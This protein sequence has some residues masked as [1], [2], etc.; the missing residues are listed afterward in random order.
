[1]YLKHGFSKEALADQ[2]KLMKLISPCLSGGVFDSPYKFLKKYD[3]MTN[4]LTKLFFCN[5][6]E[7]EMDCD[8]KTGNP[9]L[10]Q[11]CGHPFQKSKASYSVFLPLQPQIA[12]FIENHLN[13]SSKPIDDD[14]IGDVPTGRVY[15]SYKKKGKLKENSLTLQWNMDGAR[16][17]ELSEYGFM[18]GMGILNE[19]KHKVRRTNIILF[20][21]WYGNKKPQ[22]KQF[23]DRLIEMLNQLSDVGVVVNGVKWTVH[24][25]IVSVDTIER[26][27]LRGTTQF[28]GAFGC[29]FCLIEGT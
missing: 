13:D 3:A 11:A 29:D 8:P 6:S 22:S 28:N 24:L 20:G 21:I 5:V 17:F 2:L 16:C 23:L 26:C 25:L 19:A 4:G 27:I 12:Y 10:N 1:M 15:K 9:V 18:P 14:E 7:T